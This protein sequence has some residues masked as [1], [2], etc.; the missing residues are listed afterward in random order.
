[1]IIKKLGYY[2]VHLEST[3]QNGNTYSFLVKA[4]AAF[5]Y[6]NN[7]EDEEET[8]FFCDSPKTPK[9][10]EPENGDNNTNFFD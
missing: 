4:L 8:Q 5:Y 10:L 3:P 2:D 6:D 9:F 7:L 1:M